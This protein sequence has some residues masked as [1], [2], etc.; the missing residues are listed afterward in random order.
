MPGERPGP[1]DTT[2]VGPLERLNKEMRGRLNAVG[3]HPNA[4]TETKLV[5]AR[6][7]GQRDA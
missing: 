6:A 4:S 3:C 2:P 1:P 5:D 7:P